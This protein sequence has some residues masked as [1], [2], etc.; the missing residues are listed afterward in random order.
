MDN[1]NSKCFWMTSGSY[2]LARNRAEVLFYCLILSTGWIMAAIDRMDQTWTQW[3]YQHKWPYLTK[4]MG[5]TL[6]EGEGLGGGD[7]SII[8]LIL[9]FCC[10]LYSIF[11]HDRRQISRWRPHLGFIL[12]AAFWSCFCNVHMLKWLIGR[13]RP[14]LV[15]EG[16]PYSHWYEFGPHFI[17]EG[18]YNG[19]FPSGHTAV[20]F[21]FMT[22]AYV[23]AGDVRHSRHIRLLGVLIG[24]Y[25]IFNALL[26]GIARTMS[27]SHWISDI[28]AS[29][30]FS[31]VT[32]HM[33]YYLVL[34]IPART[35]NRTISFSPPFWELKF[36][37]YQL[38]ILLGFM[39][40][41]MGIRTIIEQ[42]NVSLM[43]M[44]PIGVCIAGVFWKHALSVYY[45]GT[46][47]S[48]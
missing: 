32:I 7:I 45:H 13:A 22:L 16:L 40:F 11:A 37:I 19:S 9:V 44:I 42:D 30:L 1:Q 39:L 28:S 3:L 17:T 14:H 48:H 23:L 29:I 38:L 31:W 41:M 33:L 18:F 2:Y 10:Y 47:R 12:I 5:Q 21:I 36:C 26:M 35:H 34:N 46:G 43:A 6:F 20:A 8:Y 27:M 4:I 25:A 15:V 24:L